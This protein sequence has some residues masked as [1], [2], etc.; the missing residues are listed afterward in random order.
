MTTERL[1]L[2]RIFSGIAGQYEISCNKNAP[3]YREA[4]LMLVDPLCTIDRAIAQVESQ[5]D[6]YEIAVVDDIV[7]SMSELPESSEP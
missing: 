5:H 2:S 6:M 1:K 3:L 4:A 7:R